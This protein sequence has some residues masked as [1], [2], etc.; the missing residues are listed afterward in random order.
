MA[1]T[2]TSSSHGKLITAVVVVSLV[3]LLALV[4]AFVWPGW[5]LNRAT[6]D[7]AS[8]ASSSSASPSPTEPTIKAKELPSNASEL[9]K[10][11]PDSV[12]NF[13]RVEAAPSANWTSNSPLEEYTLSYQTGKESDTV[14]LIVAQWTTADGAKKQYDELT[15][16][17]KGKELASGN[18]KVSG[19]STG[20]YVVREDDTDDTKAVGLWQNGT[21]VFQATGM[22]ESVQRFYQ[23]FPL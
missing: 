12:L 6:N 21:A 10:A 1:G 15:G 23:K 18:V 11:M 9:L 2:R 4:S 7:S 20:S 22:K 3:V 13:A 5:A 19:D 16:S 17:L 8:D 14:T